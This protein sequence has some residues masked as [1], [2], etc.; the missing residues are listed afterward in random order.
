MKPGR[1]QGPGRS[2]PGVA[3]VDFP[4]HGSEARI[5]ELADGVHFQGESGLLPRFL[6]RQKGGLEAVSGSPGVP[7]ACG[8]KQ[9]RACADCQNEGNQR[10]YRRA[11]AVPPVPIAM[12]VRMEGRVRSAAVSLGSGCPAGIVGG[13]SRWVSQRL[14]GL[15]D[16]LEQ[17][18]RVR[19]SIAVRMAPPCQTAKGC[20]DL[21]G[22][23]RGVNSEDY[24]VVALR[25]DRRRHEISFPTAG[26]R[27]TR[28]RKAT[29]TPSLST[30]VSEG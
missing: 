1:G 15:V 28:T 13:S 23:D 11:D 19:R 30:R 25:T 18:S 17:R 16:G 29:S 21:G 9:R 24:V 5:V 6:L 22:A 7:V 12:G 3:E 2:V 26:Q 8:R 20:I 27:P 4:F 10:H 14:A